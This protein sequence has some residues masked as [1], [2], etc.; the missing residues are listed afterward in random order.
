MGLWIGLDPLNLLHNL[1]NGCVIPELFEVVK[2]FDIRSRRAFKVF[3]FMV[4][5]RL[6]LK[7]CCCSGDTAPAVEVSNCKAFL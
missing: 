3:I 6:D 5:L 1:L 7:D 4:K 2:D